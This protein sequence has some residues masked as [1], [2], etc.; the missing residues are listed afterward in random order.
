LVV[1][2]PTFETLLGDQPKQAGFFRE[3]IIMNRKRLEKLADFLETNPLLQK[4]GKFDLNTWMSSYDMMRDSMY[5]KLAKKTENLP[6]FDKNCN[7]IECRTVGCAMGWATTIPSFR[8]AGLKLQLDND[9]IAE[10]CL[11]TKDGYFTEMRA[12]EVFFDFDQFDH[13]R[14]PELLFLP[15]YYLEKKRRNPKAVAKRI[16]ELLKF[17]EEEFMRRHT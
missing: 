12:A 11:K 8:K 3:R 14:I 15:H 6:A 7:P 4:K 10:I 13:Y 16:R 5:Q 9:G 17:G 1:K 2:E